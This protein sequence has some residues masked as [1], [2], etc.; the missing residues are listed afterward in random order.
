M[1]SHA[2][3]LIS[4]GDFV[5]PGIVEKIKALAAKGIDFHVLGV[6]SVE[7]DWV[8]APERTYFQPH[9]MEASGISAQ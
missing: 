6:G 7:G 5:E 1:V 8:P 3:L 4:D 2:V 9:A